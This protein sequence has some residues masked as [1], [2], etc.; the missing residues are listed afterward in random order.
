MRNNSKDSNLKIS[1]INKPKSI[2]KLKQSYKLNNSLK[3]NSKLFI[4]KQKLN[5][6]HVNIKKTN[7]DVFIIE[8]LPNKD[9]NQKN[10]HHKIYDNKSNSKDVYVNRKKFD[11][12]DEYCESSSNSSTSNNAKSLKH[13]HSADNIQSN[14]NQNNYSYYTKEFISVPTYSLAPSTVK[15]MTE[16][17]N[18]KT[19]YENT[20]LSHRIN[21]LNTISEVETQQPYHHKRGEIKNNLIKPTTQCFQSNNNYSDLNKCIS[22]IDYLK[23]QEYQWKLEQLHKYNQQQN[24]KMNDLHLNLH[25]PNSIYDK[26]FRFI[27]KPIAKFNDNE[28]IDSHGF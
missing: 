19:S 16:L 17:S 5:A 28:N 13:V 1:N 2:A 18:I 6:N 12:P 27:K 20:H 26:N 10:H 9:R 7:A 4:K 22:S 11:K 21:S 24:A 8:N 23:E 15:S 25:Q 14:S 3:K